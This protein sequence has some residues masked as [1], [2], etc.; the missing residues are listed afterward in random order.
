[1]SIENSEK[2]ILAILKVLHKKGNLTENNKIKSVLDVFKEYNIIYSKESRELINI[3]N[4]YTSLDKV[5]ESLLN[6]Y[7]SNLYANNQTK[8]FRLNNNINNI[9]LNVNELRNTLK[10]LNELEKFIKKYIENIERI[11]KKYSHASVKSKSS[12]K[13][14]G[15]KKAKTI[16]W[17]VT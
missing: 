13:K 15:T 5:K 3:Y 10:N 6:I 16:K 11:K 7:N 9:F 17:F 14:T 12:V 8:L 4:F 2:T 1:M